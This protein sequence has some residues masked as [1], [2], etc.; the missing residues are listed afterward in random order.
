MLRTWWVVFLAASA[1]SDWLGPELTVPPEDTGVA[2]SGGAADE[3]PMRTQAS[4]DGALAIDFETMMGP[5]D[6]FQLGALS[7]NVSFG[8]AVGS[9]TSL[10]IRQG[11][12]ET[13]QRSLLLL[14]GELSSG[15]VG[16]HW[17]T[18]LDVATRSGITFWAKGES[19]NVSVQP[20]Y[21]G[22]LSGLECSSPIATSALTAEWQLYSYEWS[23]FCPNTS[24]PPGFLSKLTGFVFS[25]QATETT[26]EPWLALDDISFTA[27]GG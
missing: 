6:R 9:A 23:D 11:H 26:T 14:L 16:L 25:T 21:P 12:G 13:S 5:R 18:C 20:V 8:S 22:T 3:C 27:G 17:G 19:T 2:G 7:G 1:C 4:D 10:F 15:S 24:V